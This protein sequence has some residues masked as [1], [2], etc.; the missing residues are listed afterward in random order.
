LSG[1]NVSEAN[2]KIP[3]K[4]RLDDD[5]ISG[6]GFI[7]FL[8]VL[9]LIPVTWGAYHD[10][11]DSHIRDTLLREGYAINAEVTRS[12]AGRSSVDVTYRFSVDGVLYSG[13]GKI[14]ANDYKFQAP[15]EKIPIR[16]L[17]KDPRINQPVSWG[18]FSAWWAIFHL[19]GLALLAAGAA[20]IIAGLR[21]RKLERIGLV[22][23]GRVTGCVPDRTRFKVYYEFTTEDNVW[24]EGSTGM[25]KECESGDS[26]PVMYL[27]SNP[28]R[29]D[30]YPD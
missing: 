5:T 4:V 9:W 29:N 26:I 22:V 18:W 11:R 7:L 10:L 3:R 23:E 27:P 13:R 28:K 24:M 20:I 17:P 14:I 19:L 15:G 6:L 30:F 12:Y 16:Y 25:P 8:F 1:I 21:K 2:A